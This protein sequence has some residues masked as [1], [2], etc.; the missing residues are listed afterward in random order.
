MKTRWKL[1]WT[2]LFMLLLFPG[3]ALQATNLVNLNEVK[4][5]VLLRGG[6]PGDQAGTAVASGY[7]ND[8]AIAD[9][10]VGAPYSNESGRLDS[11]KAYVLLGSASFPADHALTLARVNVNLTVIGAAGGDHLGAGLAT[12]DLNGD[13]LDDF[14]IGAPGVDFSGRTNAG[15]VYVVYG[16][17]HVSVQTALDLSTDSADVTIY[18]ANAMD[19]IGKV[20]ATGNVNG[21]DYADLIIGVPDADG[22]AGRVLVIYGG[23]S[24]PAT[25]N[26]AT[27]PADMTVYA[28]T[29]GDALGASVASGDLNNDG[30][31]DLIMGAPFAQGPNHHLGSDR[32]EAYVIY[33]SG[34]LPTSLFLSSTPADI[35]VRGFAE[36]DHLGASVAATDFNGD[37]IDDLIVGAP[38]FDLTYR[39]NV[40]VV[41]VYHGGAFPANAL[42][43]GTTNSA[44]LTIY[45]DQPQDAF[46]SGL[47][48]GD[49]NNDGIGDLYI[50][51]RLGD[52]FFKQNRGKVF[53]I[54]GNASFPNRYIMDLEFGAPS[55]YV[56]GVKATDE[57]GAAVAAG[58]FDGDGFTE[59][60]V[61]APLADP[62][63]LQDKG[64]AYVVAN[65]ALTDYNAEVLSETIPRHWYPGQTQY[66]N[67]TIRNSGRFPWFAGDN[68]VL[69]AVGGTDDLAAATALAPEYT[70]VIPGGAVT[71]LIAM[72]APETPGFYTTDWRMVDADTLVPFGETVSVQVRVA[73]FGMNSAFVD[74]SVP[75]AIE[76]NGAVHPVYF[77]FRNTG[78]ADWT[79]DS[80]YEIRSGLTS[81]PFASTSTS[82]VDSAARVRT[83]EVY[84]FPLDFTAP[85]PSGYQG[86]VWQTHRSS[87][88][89]FGAKSTTHMWWGTMPRAATLLDT[90]IPRKI[91][92]GSPFSFTVTYS[93][94]GSTTWTEANDIQISVQ[95][96]NKDLW[97]NGGQT[98]WSI[99]AGASVATGQ[100][101]TFTANPMSPE[102]F[103][104]INFQL[105]LVEPGVSVFGEL[106]NRTINVIYG[107]I[108]D[109]E[110]ISQKAPEVVAAGSTFDVVI[111]MANYGAKSWLQFRDF[112]LAAVG[113]V[114]P[115]SAPAKVSLNTNEEVKAGQTRRFTISVT[116]PLTPGDYTLAYRMNQTGFG[117]FGHTAKLPIKVI[118]AAHD[119]SVI[120]YTVPSTVAVGQSVKVE[121]VMRNEGTT[122]WTAANRYRLGIHQPVAPFTVGT[123]PPLRPNE[124]VQTDDRTSFFFTMIAPD[125]PGSA[126]LT[127]QMVQDS[128]VGFFG[129]TLT[130][131]MNI[132]STVYGS[133]LVSL[134]APANVQPNQDFVITARMRNKGGF[135]W[136]NTN[137]VVLSAINLETTPFIG[138]RAAEIDGGS[139][140]EFNGEYTFQLP[141]KAPASPGGP[142]TVNL[143]MVH[144]G[145]QRFGVTVPVT[146]TVVAPGKAS[147]LQT[148]A[149]I[150]PE[151]DAALAGVTDVYVVDAAG[152]FFPLNG[153][154]LTGA[155]AAFPVIGAAAGAGSVVIADSQGILYD[156]ESGDLGNDLL[157]LPLARDVAF[158][159]GEPA[160][161][162]GLG[163]LHGSALSGGHF[164]GWDIARDLAVAGDTGAWILDG[165][166]TVYPLADSPELESAFL[167]VDAAVALA[168]FADSSGGYVLDALGRVYPVG[169]AADLG[170]L[171]DVE[172]PA[173]DLL[174]T[175]TGAGYYILQADGT[176]TAFGDAVPVDSPSLDESGAVALIAVTR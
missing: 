115:F 159:G 40:G 30:I 50:A 103:G 122:S 27:S 41:F 29:A 126:N 138:A 74:H 22:G 160:V 44:N 134:S 81:D 28:Q 83:G 71:F 161:L 140:I 60:L 142:Y 23:P 54:P 48:V 58:D 45:G 87:V 130:K 9:I 102:Q 68:F 165:F 163:I 2:A 92:G 20:L 35:E 125:S 37:G 70:P 169:S 82:P 158:I 167:G 150:A 108:R 4:P 124:V 170:S 51:A 63:N 89:W 101:H 57:L 131:S 155:E 59:L 12:G 144:L 62:E 93:N 13:G 5:Q 46:G 109:A 1:V 90:T 137:G 113:G 123:R 15:A 135:L 133:E 61:G 112:H 77:E 143:R 33:G 118:N 6:A 176:V 86:T 34:S 156:L 99:G 166:G 129:E 26:L 114:A 145:V 164:F 111:D 53:V 100:S 24:L 119:A 25:I 121:V 3:T 19:G 10:F 116:A 31:D 141:L 80:L 65:S 72:T 32:G 146:I 76:G 97:A 16:T 117:S 38:D 174:L 95:G 168:V 154:S 73:Q 127:F 162:D 152:R 128:G 147:A 157:G 172:S 149:Y 21:D 14:I 55:V 8:D 151:T 139:Q 153:G 84:R 75:V 52:G 18:G 94:G 56:L 96:G 79:A 136:T 7:F 171:V 11:G 120:S 173:V 47:A 175:E 91:P 43:F 88:K 39:T 132:I 66:A 105:R 64:A 49:D 42:R 78:T 85:S 106:L 107:P 67:I 148:S 17:P 69:G 98:N 110:I 104:P 36:N